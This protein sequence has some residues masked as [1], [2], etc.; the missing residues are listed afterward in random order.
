M[1]SVLIGCD[2]SVH[3]GGRSLTSDQR[4]SVRRQLLSVPSPLPSGVGGVRGPLPVAPV[5]SLSSP[6]LSSPPLSSLPPAAPPAPDP[7]R[8]PQ[9]RRR[10]NAANWGPNCGQPPATH[11]GQVD[12]T[13]LCP[14]RKTKLAWRRAAFVMCRSGRGPCPALAWDRH[15]KW[16]CSQMG[17][18]P[19]TKFLLNCGD[20]CSYLQRFSVLWKN[21]RDTYLQNLISRILMDV[22]YL[23]HQHF[24][25]WILDLVRQ[26]CSRILRILDLAN[27]FVVGSCGY[28][29]L[30]F[31]P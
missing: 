2:A 18:R 11:A 21:A 22:A 16:R 23:L 13:S 26:V 19:L 4:L 5:L 25:K 9:W 6:P 12:M 15:Q 14:S 24:L 8:R 1:R 3:Y 20:L 31:W 7:S 17:L 30:L 29:I 10:L 28:W 27:C